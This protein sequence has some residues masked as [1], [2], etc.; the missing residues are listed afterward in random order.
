MRKSHQCAT[1]QLDFNLPERFKLEY[2]SDDGIDRPVIV[3]R[4]IFGSL[5]RFFAI[6]IEHTAGEWPFWLNPRQLLVI[7]IS[8]AADAYAEKVKQVFWDA[9]FN[10][11][12]DLSDKKLNKKLMNV[13]LE[14]IFNYVLVVGAKEEANGTVNIRTR[15]NQVLGEFKIEELINI[16]S[17]AVRNFKEPSFP[18][19]VAAPAASQ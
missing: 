15:D 16:L 6:L 12:T 7:P 1:I 9:S 13:R 4:A 19:V 3:H 8:Q 14:A 11:E 17:D 10:V 2:V 18:A 5:E